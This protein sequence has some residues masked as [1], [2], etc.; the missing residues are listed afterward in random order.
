MIVWGHDSSFQRAEFK[1]A[2]KLKGESE[3]SLTSHISGGNYWQVIQVQYVAG[4][5]NCGFI[6]LHELRMTATVKTLM[7]ET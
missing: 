4:R 5:E 3:F 1:L 2:L 7:T 6:V